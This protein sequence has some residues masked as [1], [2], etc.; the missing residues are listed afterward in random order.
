[1]HLV[2]HALKRVR[3]LLFGSSES[4]RR[5]GTVPGSEAGQHLVGARPT[6]QKWHRILA[7]ARHRRAPH[8]WPSP[9]QCDP[10]GALVRAYVLPE[11]ERMCALA[12]PARET[13]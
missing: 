11:D 1:M 9:A 7:E 13:R 10:V 3:N 12:S 2:S 5:V 6:P 4:G 8:L